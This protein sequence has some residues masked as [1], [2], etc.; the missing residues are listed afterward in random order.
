VIIKT[1]AA[2]RLVARRAGPGGQSIEHAAGAV[3]AVEIAGAD[4]VAAPFR[5]LDL[6]LPLARAIFRQRFPV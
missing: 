3:P 6:E 5:V 1:L 4:Q 2:A